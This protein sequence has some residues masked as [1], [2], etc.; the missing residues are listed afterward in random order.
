[1]GCNINHLPEVIYPGHIGS[2]GAL[3]MLV[4]VV[5]E[6]VWRRR[7]SRRRRRGYSGV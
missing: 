3:I 6:K 2:S 1:M 5:G 7:W 4:S